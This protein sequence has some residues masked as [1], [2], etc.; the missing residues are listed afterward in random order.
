MIDNVRM[1]LFA[2][3]ISTCYA[4]SNLDGKMVCDDNE[5][6]DKKGYKSLL[7]MK[8]GEWYK[9]QLQ[10]F[11]DVVYPNYID[12]ETVESTIKFFKKK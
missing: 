8:D 12:N 7:N 6:D 5:Y 2:R 10:Y 9:E 1:C 3:W 11:I 4:V